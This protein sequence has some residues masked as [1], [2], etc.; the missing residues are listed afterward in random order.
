MMVELM[1]SYS[2]D[3]MVHHLVVY[4]VDLKDEM[5]VVLMVV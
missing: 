1:A 5:L 2:A 4:S 3:S